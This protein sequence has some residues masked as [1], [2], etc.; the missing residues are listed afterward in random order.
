MNEDVQEAEKRIKELRQQIE[1]HN[2]RYYILDDPEI[3]DQEF[4]QLMQELKQLEEKYPE[5]TTPNSPTQRV[6][7]EPAKEFETVQ[8]RLPMLSLDN[9]FS[10][11]DLRAFDKRVRRLLESEEIEYVAELKIDGAAVS[12]IYEN[13]S[14]VQGATRGN[15]R[16]GENITHNLRTIRSIP[17]H[18][19]GDPP[20][21][22]EVRGEVY[23]IKSEFEKLN[24]E[25]AKREESPFAN[26]RNAAAGSLRQLD[27]KI[28]ASRPLDIFIYGIGY[29]ED[30]GVNN[31]LEALKYVKALGLKTN[32]N[33][34]ICKDIE[35]VILY[36]ERW[37]EDE[38]KLDYEIDGVVVKVNS[39]S[40]QEILG[41]TSHNPR[42]AIAY[43]FPPEEATTKVQ[44]IIVQVGRTG[45]LT[46]VAILEPRLIAGSVVSRATL[47]NEDEIRRKDVRIGD[48]VIVHKAGEVIPE[49]VRVLKERRVG[50]EI[51]FSMPDRCPVCGGEVVRLEGEAATRCIGVSCPAQ[52]KEHIRHFASRNAMDIEK[53]GSATIDQLVDKGLVKDVADLYFLDKE[54][55]LGLDRMADKS[56]QNLFDAIADSKDR[57]LSR[58]IFGLGIRNVG[59][60]ASRI[61]ADNFNSLEGLSQAEKEQLADIFEIGPVTA[62]SIVAFF[63]AEETKELLKKLKRAE[64]RT[65][66][67]EEAKIISSDIAGKTFVLTGK[68]ANYTRSEIQDLIIQAG[69][70]VTSSVSAKTDYVIAGESSGSKFTKAQELGIEILTGGE[71]EELLN[72]RGKN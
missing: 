57:D 11:D 23:M 43:K 68:L 59:E 18:L 6:G 28:T 44:D 24:R 69:G 19:R 61:L 25:R 40:Q 72:L 12:L 50:E 70:R 35:E 47:H 30:K 48:T 22:I 10:A 13:G 41:A 54:T 53:L 67:K 5:L 27:P 9:A 7:A 4:D 58:L 65:A 38:E 62:D 49:V 37:Q 66:K 15:G 34:K 8:H 16:Q 64:V 3:S 71:F 56:A 51:E 1:H 17:L 21:L 2:Y 31:H 46:P 32:P 39:F 14:F 55:L 63:R 20:S 29:I 52:L 26:P 60:R 33:I 42:W 45:I 36:C